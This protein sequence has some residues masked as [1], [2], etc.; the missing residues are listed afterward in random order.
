VGV[1][2]DLSVVALAQCASDE[3]VETELLGPGDL[4]DPVHR[5]ADGDVRDR[6]GHVLGVKGAISR[7]GL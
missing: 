1:G 4:D 7:F 2:S 5:R 3:F 6:A